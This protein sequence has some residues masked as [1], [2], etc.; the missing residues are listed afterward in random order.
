MLIMF[1]IYKEHASALPAGGFST[2]RSVQS[3]RFCRVQGWGG[4]GAPCPPHCCY[5]L[6]IY[7]STSLPPHTSR[8]P[9]LP[10]PHPQQILPKRR[11]AHGGQRFYGGSAM[12]ARRCVPQFPHRL[13]GKTP[14]SQLGRGW[15]VL[16]CAGQSWGGS[17]QNWLGAPAESPQMPCSGIRNTDIKLKILILRYYP[18]NRKELIMTAPP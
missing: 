10:S 15:D 12:G 18:K 16:G 11:S 7:G 5:C 6:S 13:L 2:L 1:F 17:G 9:L 3:G 14:N 4:R 8:V